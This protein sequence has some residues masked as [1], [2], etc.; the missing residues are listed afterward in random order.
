M[1]WRYKRK[2]SFNQF[3]FRDQKD[4]K[5]AEDLLKAPVDEMLPASGRTV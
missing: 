5:E 2:R 3:V 1:V 4:R